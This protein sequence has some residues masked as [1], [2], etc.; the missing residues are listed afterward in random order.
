MASAVQPCVDLLELWQCD[1]GAQ[2]RAPGLAQLCA[3]V[4]GTPLD[5]RMRLSNWARRPLTRHQMEYA[6]L[7]AFCLCDLYAALLSRRPGIAGRHVPASECDDKTIGQTSIAF[8]NS[9]QSVDS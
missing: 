1:A 2:P 5:K 4:L 3:L 6:A 8:G 7:D 9:L